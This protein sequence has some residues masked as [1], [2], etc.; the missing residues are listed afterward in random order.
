[1]RYVGI[2]VIAMLLSGCSVVSVK[3]VGHDA[4]GDLVLCNNKRQHQALS[5]FAS[6]QRIGLLIGDLFTD[7]WRSG[8]EVKARR[9]PAHADPRKAATGSDSWY[10]RSSMRWRPCWRRSWRGWAVWA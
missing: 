6:F 8:A 3:W 5:L 7:G 10:R 1:M 4:G 2:A 9:T